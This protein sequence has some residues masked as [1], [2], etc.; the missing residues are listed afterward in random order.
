M[1][2]HSYASNA[3]VF[4]GKKPYPHG[5]PDGTSNTIFYIEAYAVCGTN[6]GLD[7]PN[8]DPRFRAARVFDYSEQFFPPHRPTF[9][10]GGT[11]FGGYNKKEVYPVTSGG[12]TNPSRAGATFQ[13]RPAVAQCD[14]SYPQTPYSSGLLASIG[15]GSVRMIRSSINPST[16][17]SAV[18]PD[19][20]EVAGDF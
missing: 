6:S 16:F 1:E 15:D 4:S 10:E 18:T 9:A 14:P 11:L 20:G 8:S 19:G 7:I 3:Q 2:R 12:I 13:I 5:I 17:W